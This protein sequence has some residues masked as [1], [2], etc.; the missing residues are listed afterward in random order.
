MS[1]LP[2]EPATAIPT[3]TN[4]SGVAYDPTGP[5]LPSSAKFDPAVHL[6][7]KPTHKKYTFEELGLKHKGISPVAATEVRSST[8]SRLVRA[9]PDV[10]CVGFPTL[11]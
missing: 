6:C 11:Y 4:I 5:R 2:S 7:Y 8:I 3:L 9:Q 1:V 10:V